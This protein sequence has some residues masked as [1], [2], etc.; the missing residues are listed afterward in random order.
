MKIHVRG[1]VLIA[2]RPVGFGP[3]WA[4]KVAQHH[5]LLNKIYYKKK[6]KKLTLA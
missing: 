5:S 4:V 1:R 3:G 2:R 6:K